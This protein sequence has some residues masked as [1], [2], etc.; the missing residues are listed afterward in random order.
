MTK[1]N[2][3][4]TLVS[5]EA[6]RARLEKFVQSTKTS[7]TSPQ[8]VQPLKSIA[9]MNLEPEHKKEICVTK[10]DAELDCILTELKDVIVCKTQ[11]RMENVQYVV[12]K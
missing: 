12:L 2:Q 1:G 3:M 8:L 9:Y 4:R 5:V 10:T 6:Q 11:T 7:G